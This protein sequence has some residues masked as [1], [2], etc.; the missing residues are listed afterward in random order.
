MSNYLL[1]TCR[2]STDDEI[3][4]EAIVA[5]GDTFEERLYHAQQ[6]AQAAIEIAIDIAV[7]NDAEKG[8]VHAHTMRWDDHGRYYHAMDG[9][10]VINIQAV[11]G[12]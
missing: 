11:I 9:V 8:A 10:E 7:E 5:E 6:Q 4:V 12:D 1:R 2:G 3:S